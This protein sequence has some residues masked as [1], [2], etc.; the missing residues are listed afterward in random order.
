MTTQYC[1][2]IEWRHTVECRTQVNSQGS[3]S[4]FRVYTSCILMH[5]VKGFWPLIAFEVRGFSCSELQK[6]GKGF[7][8]CVF[9]DTVPYPELHYSIFKK[10]N[11]EFWTTKYFLI[12]HNYE[13]LQ[14]FPS[15]KITFFPLNQSSTVCTQNSLV[16]YSIPLKWKWFGP[17]IHWPLWTM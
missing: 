4:D 13:A 7:R 14:Y 15:M 9:V 8:A 6:S 10:L 16:D 1:V 3:T 2:C 11:F 17:N 12:K 5:W